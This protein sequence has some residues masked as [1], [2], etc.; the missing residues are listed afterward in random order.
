MLFETICGIFFLII[1]AGNGIGWNRQEFSKCS[2]S[3]Q[4]YDQ[5][6]IK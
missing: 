6:E 5:V 3:A 2:A 1:D 4:Y